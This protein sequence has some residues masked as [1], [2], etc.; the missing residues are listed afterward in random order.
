MEELIQCLGS[1]CPRNDKATKEIVEIQ[2][3][4]V[5]RDCI[6]LHEPLSCGGSHVFQSKGQEALEFLQYICCNDIDQ[7]IGTIIH[8]GMLNSHGGYENDCSIVPLRDNTYV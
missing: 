3:S 5:L 2:S 6:D 4:I 8:T 7:G 1:G